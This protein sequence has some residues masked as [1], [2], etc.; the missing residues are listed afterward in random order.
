MKNKNWIFKLKSDFLG[1]GSLFVL[2]L[3]FQ[4]AIPSGLTILPGFSF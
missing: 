1:S 3:L 4:A 2:D